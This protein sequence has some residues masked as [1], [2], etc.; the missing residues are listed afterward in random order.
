MLILLLLLLAYAEASVS[1]RRVVVVGGGAAGY[2]SAI[3]C[4]SV[5]KNAQV[6]YEVRI[7][8][9]RCIP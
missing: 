5:L 8:K 1:A 2:F 9:F 6:P 3:Q 4:A 7:F